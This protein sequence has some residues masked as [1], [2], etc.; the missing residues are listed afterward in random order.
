[1]S[2]C[3]RGR[4][5]EDPGNAFVQEGRRNNENCILYRRRSP[6]IVSYFRLLASLLVV[7]LSVFSFSEM[8]SVM[9]VIIT[10][11]DVFFPKCER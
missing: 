1:M 7:H 8:P 2:C 6:N 4:N 11:S 9:S 5:R 10:G 3:P